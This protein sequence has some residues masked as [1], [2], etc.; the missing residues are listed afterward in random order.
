MEGMLGGR[1]S[2]V[3]SK[4][5]TAA[6]ITHGG[7]LC[8]INKVQRLEEENCYGHPINSSETPA[9][10]VSAPP[11]MTSILRS[12]HDLEWLLELQPLLPH[13]RQ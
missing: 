11:H 10:S 9:P 5:P 6:G 12:F 8:H 1:A 13:S 2:A 7:L 4:D 3:M